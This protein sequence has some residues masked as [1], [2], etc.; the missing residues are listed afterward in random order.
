MKDEATTTSSEEHV[1][2]GWRGDESQA[3]PLVKEVVDSVEDLTVNG[4]DWHDTRI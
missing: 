3:V 2:G 1:R 4:V